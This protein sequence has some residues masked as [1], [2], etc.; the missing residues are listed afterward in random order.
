MESTTLN[1]YLVGLALALVL[2][3]GLL[4]GHR[5]GLNREKRREFNI[6]VE[7]IREQ[8][9]N[10][11][12]LEA[13]QF[14]VLSAEQIAQIRSVMSAIHR[15][16]FEKKYELYVQSLNSLGFTKPDGSVG[17]SDPQLIEKHLQKV[18]THLQNK[19]AA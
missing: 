14:P 19:A 10:S 15:R 1:L 6:I 17:F 11:H 9:I 3:A 7:P 12:N 13:Q 8:L 18:L 5:M 2:F 4:F 16:A